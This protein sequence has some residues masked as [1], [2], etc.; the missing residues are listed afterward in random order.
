MQTTQPKPASHAG[1][2]AGNTPL[3]Q[4][5]LI[6]EDDEMDALD[7]RRR[8][9]RAFADDIEV[10][11]VETLA[12]AVERLEEESFDLAFLD[13]R[14]PDTLPDDSLRRLG[15]IEGAPPLVVMTGMDDDATANRALRD[16]AQDYLVKGDF[17]NRELERTV[18]FA[19]ERHLLQR[20]LVRS[21]QEESAMKDRLLSHVSH[22][23]RT[24][25]TA[26]VQ[27]L[28]IVRDGIAGPVTE[29]QIEYLGVASRNADQLKHMITTLVDVSRASS[30]K[31]DCRLRLGSVQQVA[32]NVCATFQPRAAEA[33][34]T[35]SIDTTD[36]ETT[37]AIDATRVVEVL[38][39]LV[40][41][42]L[43]FTPPEGRVDLRVE[44]T[45]RDGVEFVRVTV[46]D[47]G[48][49]IPTEQLEHVFSRLHQIQGNDDSSR[50]GLGLGLY[51]AREIVDRH[52]G[53]IWADHNPGGGT[54][55]HLELPAHDLRRYVEKPARLRTGIA[56]AVSLLHIR[57]RATSRN[58]IAR[59]VNSLQETIE[60]FATDSTIATTDV[61]LP[62]PLPRGRAVQVFALTRADESGAASVAE[63]IRALLADNP[64]FGGGDYEHSVTT[65]TFH[66]P[67]GVASDD[68][69]HQLTDMI[70]RRIDDEREQP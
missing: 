8:I 54:A 51:L 27:F 3:L 33:G 55:M 24:P 48:V 50:R 67:D 38:S 18:R 34:I 10:E 52:D 21:K 23:L 1:N 14:L 37:A 16:G 36:A 20:D 44:R 59:G 22:E 70:R 35:L 58:A 25:L 19:V 66:A 62:S 11:H 49:G 68:A 17:S 41:N 57:V 39:N 4:R 63:R 69:V 31:L 32:E 47:S 56:P 42:A 9:R 61:V 45:R 46:A 28:A 29:K 30:D 7:L 60:Q 15:A 13:L 5:I 43:K 65:S 53:R 12:R 2:H 64:R 40:D 26:I 6:V